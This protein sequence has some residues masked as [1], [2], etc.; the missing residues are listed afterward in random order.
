MG[1]DHDNASPPTA[2]LDTDGCC[3]PE[4]S[5]PSSKASLTPRPTEFPATLSP[6]TADRGEWAMRRCVDPACLVAKATSFV[7]ICTC[8][9][10][11]C[12]P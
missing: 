4:M 1:E 9:H 11:R 5:G 2:T 10:E 6:V 3:C 7:P 12:I 8:C